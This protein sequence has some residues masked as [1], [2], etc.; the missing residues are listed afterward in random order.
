[1]VTH[2]RREPRSLLERISKSIAQK[3]PGCW[4]H[5]PASL[6]RPRRNRSPAWRD[7]Q[8]VNALRAKSPLPHG[9]ARHFELR[10]MSMLRR[11]RRFAS[12]VE[13]AKASTTADLSRIA[14]NFVIRRSPGANEY[15]GESF[16]MRDE[17]LPCSARSE[18]R[19]V[20]RD[21]AT[22]DL[23]EP[24]RSPRLDHIYTVFARWSPAWTGRRHSRRRCD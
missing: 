13:R 19:R 3:R 5:G 20:G 23:R 17:R 9:R 10:S 11:C 6:A 12:H 21:T 15:S 2:R 1:M 24:Y 16:Y 18:S 4:P 14:P 8:S 22:R 7:D